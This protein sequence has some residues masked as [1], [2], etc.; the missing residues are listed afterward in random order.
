MAAAVGSDDSFY[1]GGT[2][3]TIGTDVAANN[4]AHFKNGAW[5]PLGNGIGGAVWTLAVKAGVGTSDEVYAGGIFGGSGTA[6]TS[7]VAKWNGS[8]WSSLGPGLNQP[9]SILTIAPDG[10]I[11]AGGEFTKSGDVA[12]NRIAVWDGQAWSPLGDG[13]A[14]GRVASIAIGP[15]GKVYAGGTFKKSGT[16]NV[17]GIAVWN[18]SVWTPVG[19]GVEGPSAFATSGVYDIGFYDNKLTI[20]GQFT[21]PSVTPDG[22]VPPKLNNVAVFDGTSWSPVGGGLPSKSA[23]FNNVQARRMMIRG[24][25]LYVA[26]VLEL[27]GNAIADAGAPEAVKHI[28]KWDGTKWSEV[29]GGL[30]DAADEI[31]SDGKS[32]WV[33][34]AFTWAGDRGS[35]WIARYWYGQ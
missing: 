30:S 29:G 34:G 17:R 1:V 3:G 13:F 22:G 11:Y 9:V 7:N 12:M 28:A 21:K 4:V 24:N 18:G 23:L 16:A 32:L 31:V 19:G 15:D 27:L 33:V 2:F 20:T 25:D 14:D 10:K 35:S 8:A 6:V 26:G 5:H